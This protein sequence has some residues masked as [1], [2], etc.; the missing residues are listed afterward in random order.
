MSKFFTVASA[1]A[2]L[3]TT[4]TTMA[5][6]DETQAF[7]AE[8]IISFVVD[9]Q[10]DAVTLASL[11]DANVS[12]ILEDGIAVD[13]AAAMRIDALPIPGAGDLDRGQLPQI[14]APDIAPD[15]TVVEQPQVEAAS[16]SDL[17]SQ[18]GIPSALNDEQKCL[19]GAVYFESKGETLQ[20]QLAVAKVVLARRES[21][22]FPN[23]VCGVVYQRSQFSFVRGGKMPSIN[24][25]SRAWQRAVAIS[26]IAIQ[27][28]WDSKVEG[29]LFFHARTV[30]PGWR[31]TRM[32]SVDNHIFYR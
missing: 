18:T 20:G 21:S 5:L 32:A 12:P 1:A 29:A 13:T 31:L 3:T 28:K 23:S 14:N 27:D 25:E 26:E 22:R 2:I 11:N 19:A 17:V 30:S 7:A 8:G 15:I 9:Q 6:T 24:T 16:L 10:T 4:L